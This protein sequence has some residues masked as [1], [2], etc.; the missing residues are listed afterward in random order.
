MLTHLL[1]DPVAHAPEN[2]LW[3]LL[4][5]EFA[6]VTLLGPRSTVATDAA[7]VLIVAFVLW[8]VARRDRLPLLFWRGQLWRR[9]CWTPPEILRTMGYRDAEH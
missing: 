2:L 8:S 5:G 3:P 4:G 6:K 7:A 1:T 9:S